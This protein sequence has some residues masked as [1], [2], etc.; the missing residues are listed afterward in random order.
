MNLSTKSA[1][2]FSQRP[3]FR[4]SLRAKVA[5]GVALPVFLAL[6]VIS[7]LHY[8]REFQAMEEQARLYAID[9]GDMLNKSVSHAMLIK[10]NQHLMEVLSDVGS[11]EQ[12]QQV[13]IVGISGKVLI[14]SDEARLAQQLEISDLECWVCHQ[15]PEMNRPRTAEIDKSNALLRIASPIPNQNQCWGCH[16]EKETHLGVLL[17]DASLDESISHLREDLRI[18]LVITIILTSLTTFGVYWLV[19]S[20]VVHRIERLKD[21]IVA[22]TSGDYNARAFQNDSNSQDELD[23]LA[24]SFN[25][26]A[27]EIQSYTHKLDELSEVRQKA[28]FDE[29][30]RI[31]RELHDGVAQVL[32]P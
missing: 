16:E 19:S 1:R 27:D 32:V 13:Q 7:G 15:F 4:T 12:I 26:M 11:M 24:T 28:I 10:N 29:R 18:D 8:W 2:I 9:L 23:Q 5:I 3:S 31:A 22:Y 20:Q 25:H 14:S 30:E 21:P 6:M 17:I